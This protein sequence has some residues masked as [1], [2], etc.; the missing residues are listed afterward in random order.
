MHLYTRGPSGMHTPPGS[1]THTLDMR[2]VGGMSHLLSHSTR[3]AYSTG[4]TLWPIST[5]CSRRSSGA[6][7]T[8]GALGEGEPLSI[9]KCKLC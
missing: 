7:G 3:V 6:R 8:R 1:H 4:G 2:T 9:E 5:W